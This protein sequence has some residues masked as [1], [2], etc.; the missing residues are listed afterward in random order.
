MTQFIDP[1]IFRNNPDLNIVKLEDN[2]WH[3]DCTD[4]FIMYNFL[5]DPPAKTSETSLICQSPANVSGYSW[6]SACFDAWNGPTYPSRDRTWG[7]VLIS[8]LTV[9]VLFGS[10]VSVRHMMRIKRRAME[11]R[12]Q[13]ETLR[14]LRQRR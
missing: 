14:P 8:A 6:E 2:P 10:F 4:L 3:C 12:L 5:T 1:D 9:I 7:F 11:Q 13:Q